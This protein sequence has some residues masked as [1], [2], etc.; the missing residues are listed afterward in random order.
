MLPRDL[1]SRA[2]RWAAGFRHQ[3]STSRRQD[4]VRHHPVR[5]SAAP[6]PKVPSAG[7]IS[8]LQPS[9][10][11]RDPCYVRAKVLAPVRPKRSVTSRQ[12]VRP[13]RAIPCHLGLPRGSPRSRG[14]D[15]SPRPLQPTHDTSTRGPFDFRA[16]GLRR[17]D[18]R[19]LPLPVRA[20]FFRA[21]PDRLA[22]IQPRL[23]TRLTARLQLRPFAHGAVV[24]FRPD[25]P[26]LH[27]QGA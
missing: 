1:H 7:S 27:P 22:A 3:A 20:R 12:G 19:M 10:A 14:E 15:A 26:E 23:G 13:L 2:R 11:L 17:T 9:E 5:G 21:T 25:V 18:R 6:E 24:A 4:P 8:T 16:H